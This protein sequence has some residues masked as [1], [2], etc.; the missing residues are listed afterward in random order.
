MDTNLSPLKI[1][2]VAALT[3]LTGTHVFAA[4]NY[5]DYGTETALTLSTAR[6]QRV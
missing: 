1:S 6:M 3:L 4:A 2:V 5:G